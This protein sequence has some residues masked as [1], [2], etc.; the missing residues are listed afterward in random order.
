MFRKIF[1]GWWIVAS[2]FLISIAVSGVVFFGFTAFVEPIKEE[3]GW[4]Y[5]QISLAASLRGL[6]MGIFAPLVGFL[7]DRFG[8]RKLVFFGM[9]TIGCGLILLSSIQSLAMFYCAFL[10]IAFGAGGCAGVVLT[11]A[12]ANW[13]HKNVGLALGAMGSGVGI[14]GLIIPLIVRLID[15]YGWKSS[16]VILGLS[17]WAVGIPLSFIIRNR[18]EEYGYVPDGKTTLNQMADEKKTNEQPEISLR[19]AFTMRSFWYINA[20]ELARYATFSAV[21]THVMPYLGSVGLPRSTASLVASGVAFFTIFG[22]FS[23][24][25]L[26]DV[27]NKKY[28]LALSLCL[29]S[30]GVLAFSFAYVWWMLVIFL[31]LFSPAVGGLMTLRGAIVRDYFGRNS[32]GKIVGIIMGTAAVGGIIGPTLAGWVFDTYQSYQV[33]WLLSCG[34]TGAAISLALKIR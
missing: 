8:A 34:I 11:T 33:F 29:M 19:Q 23:F 24:G 28:I 13:F 2:C 4:S 3:F 31:L 22:R 16:C 7:V 20:L 25:W 14:G 18:P 21:V 30:L 10:V 32:Y 26:G 17:M 27:F 15:V 9:A 1:Y 6:E 12:V 5:T